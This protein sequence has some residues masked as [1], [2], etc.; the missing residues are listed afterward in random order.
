VLEDFCGGGG[1]HMV[2]RARVVRLPAYR[3]SS[4]LLSGRCVIRGCVPKKLLVYG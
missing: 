2:F 3:R 1:A 4:V